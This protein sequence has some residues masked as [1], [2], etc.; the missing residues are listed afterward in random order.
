MINRRVFLTVLLT[1]VFSTAK[2]I[3]WDDLWLNH[4]EQGYR[5]LMQGKPNDAAQLFVKP[6]WQGTAYYRMGDYE[7][8]LQAFSSANDA[9][10]FYNRG[11]ALAHLGRYQ[12]AINAYDK[13]LTLN[14]HFDDATFNRELVKKLL[15]SQSSTSTSQ[16]TPPFKKR[17][18]DDKNN[19]SDN[20]S[21]SSENN[22]STSNNQTPTNTPAE[23]EPQPQPSEPKQSEAPTQPQTQ[24]QSNSTP[25][26]LS[27]NYQTQQQQQALQNMNDDPGGLLQRKFARD[28]ERSQQQGD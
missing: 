7:H 6:Q 18:E 10:A 16:N 15:H 17:Y 4:D 5:A 20:H 23:T 8:A 25:T 21:S 3:T 12:E 11:N 19:P 24:S 9:T 13:A 1:I 14:S 26:T 28:Y 2:A 27:S 22:S